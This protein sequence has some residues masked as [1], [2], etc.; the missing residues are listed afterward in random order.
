[1][2]SDRQNPPPILVILED[3]IVIFLHTTEQWFPTFYVC[4]PKVAN[5]M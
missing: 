5:G 4:D 1:M 3:G 2:L